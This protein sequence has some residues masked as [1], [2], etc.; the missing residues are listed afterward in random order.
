MTLTFNLMPQIKA[1]IGKL[2]ATVRENAKI[3]LIEKLGWK[4]DD[5]RFEFA[6]QNTYLAAHKAVLQ[7]I[8]RKQKFPIASVVVKA[9]NP[10]LDLVDLSVTYPKPEQYAPDKPTT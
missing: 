10:A 3:A 8:T 6:V 4:E 2:S 9:I 7:T 5:A 1:D